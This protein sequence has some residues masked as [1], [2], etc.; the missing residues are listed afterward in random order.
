MPYR[1]IC[2]IALL[3]AQS[4]PCLAAEPVRIRVLT[5]NIHHAEG[6]DGRLDLERIAEV[7]QAADA[8]IVALQE[9]DQLVRRS[10]SV[11]QV[12]EL[13]KKTGM[14]SVFGA[15]IE[16]QGGHYGNAILSRWPFHGVENQPLPNFQ[17]GEQRGCLKAVVRLPNTSQALTILATHFDHRPLEDERLASAEFINQLVAAEPTAP[18]LLLGDLNAVPTSP[19]LSRLR[20]MWEVCD[21]QDLKTIPVSA[22]SRQIDYVLYRPAKLWQLKNARVIDEPVASDHLPLLAELELAELESAIGK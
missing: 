5:Y 17:Q 7:I 11:E 4:I 20:D 13:A 6:V 16:L 18:A 19:T 22:P 12:A 15:N 1:L 2:F 14:Y 9:V 10:G 21:E 8:D 3:L